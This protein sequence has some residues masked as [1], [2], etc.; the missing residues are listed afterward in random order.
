MLT[1]TIVTLILGPLVLALLFWAPPLLFILFILVVAELTFVEYLNLIPGLAARQRNLMMGLA[2]AIVAGCSF[3]PG[4]LA[5][6]RMLFI[7]IVIFLALVFQSVVT[8][9]DNNQALNVVAS[10]F[11][12]LIYI[13]F[14]LALL[15]PIRFGYEFR[16][17]TD[18]AG[19]G[20]HSILFL[21]LVTWAGDIGAYLV[22]RFLGRQ[23]LAPSI[24]PGKTVEGAVAGLACSLCVGFVYYS[25]KGSIQWL[26]F[27][28]LFNI[29]G[30]FGDL[31]ESMLKRGAGVKDSSQRLPGH[32]GLLDRLDSLLVCCPVLFLLE[33]MRGG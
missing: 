29:I 5:P 1:R 2:A 15:V 4:F 10:S 28:V 11:F 24:S 17:L 6:L 25:V 27:A 8:V 22:G 16:L 9:T 30:Q 14:F 19:P 20:R 23:K 13:P 31:F 32:G 7:L 21:L 26:I 3:G 12:G 18:T 33:V